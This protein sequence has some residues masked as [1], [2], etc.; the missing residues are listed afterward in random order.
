MTAEQ[1][2][3]SPLL[4][5][6]YPQQELFLC[7]I[8]DAVLKSDMASLEHP[9]FSLT[10]K[11]EMEPRRYEHNGNF[12]EVIPSHLGIATILDRDILIFAVS[13]IM[14]AKKQG[15]KYTKYVKFTATDF[16]IFTNRATDGRA[17]Q[18][19]KDALLR[20]QGTQLNTNVKTGSTEQENIFGL[21]GS[22]IMIKE[23]DTGR[24]LEW[25]IE[26]SDWLFNAI[27]ADEVLTLH[28]GYFRL[29][30]PL[31]RR[32][33]E[34]A[35]KHC[36]RQTE[37]KVSIELL[38]KKC[39][40]ASP[41][42]HFRYILAGLAQENHL[43]DYSVTLEEDFVIFTNRE[44]KKLLAQASFE[45]AG[46]RL[47]GEAYHD[48]RLAAPGWDVYFLEEQWRGWMAMADDKPRNPDR[49]F[50]G[51]CAKWFQKRGRP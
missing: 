2:S 39:G 20:L 34:I 40:S 44:E 13:Q 31:E 27:D 5:D 14:A 32:I 30:K 4:P 1:M 6:R 3:A 29:R 7:D 15:R 10:R 49:A 26:L 43:P 51:F 16:L 48:A 41:R 37:W 9:I 35:R 46:I 11:P 36:G 21:I 24:V 23:S 12:L 22:A 47:S 25:G 45:T 19:L 18:W 17:Y 8:A 50:I 28:P 42:K 38:Q 33:Y